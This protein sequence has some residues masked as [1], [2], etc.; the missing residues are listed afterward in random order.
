MIGLLR[1]WRALKRNGVVGLNARNGAY[2][3]TRNDRR[4]YPL[5][6]DKLTTK[7]LAEEAGIAVPPLYGVIETEHDVHRLEQIVGE[8]R[9]FVVKPANGSGGDGIVVVVGRTFRGSGHFRLAGG[10]LMGLDDLHHHVSNALNGQYS[11][12]GHPD[13]VMIEHCVQADP[14]F[15]H[16]SHEGVPD[17]RILVYRGVPVMAMVRLPTRLSGGK[18]NLHQGAVGVGVDIG[19]GRTRG[20]VLG[21]EPVDVHPDSGAAIGDVGVPHWQR[22]LEIAAGCA[23]I[24]GLGYLGVDL[25]LDRELGPVMLELNARPGL[26]IQIANGSGLQHRLSAVDAWNPKGG[27]AVERA[28]WAQARFPAAR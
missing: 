5:V 24:T 27:S 23:D 2:I 13:R 9:R 11:L 15:E 21:N 14:V 20:G 12:G 8:H 25:V 1:T 7:R 22:M 19:T 17:V 3:L 18:A 16:I 26:N 28:A 10:A 4:R 6:D